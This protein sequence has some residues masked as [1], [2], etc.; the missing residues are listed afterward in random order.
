MKKRSSMKREDLYTYRVTWSAEDS[1]FVA[2]V[3]EFPGLSWLA[4]SRQ[5]AID[6]VISVVK[7]VLID[8]K[9]TGEEIPEPI[10]AKNYS[11]KLN[12]RLGPDLHKVVALKAAERGESLNTYLVKQLSAL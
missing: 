1:E 3:V 12:L 6:G 7:E 9:Q 5:A 10:G 4:T 8:M 11:G 2:T